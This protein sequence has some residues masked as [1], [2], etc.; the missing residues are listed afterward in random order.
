MDGRRLLVAATVLV[1]IAVLVLTNGADDV[2]PETTSAVADAAIT[3]TTNPPTST[4][5]PITTTAP[6]STSSTLAPITTGAPDSEFLSAI[7]AV[8]AD[9]LHASWREGCPLAIEG[10]SAVDVSFWSYNGL[11]NTGRLIVATDLA[12]DMVAIMQDL[13]EA[14]FP[15]ERMAPVDAFGGD[16]D[17]S[18][19]ANNTSAF[20]CRQVTGGSAWSEHSYGRAIDINPLVNPY[21]RGSTVLPPEG[22]AYA[23]RERDAPGMIHAGDVVVDVFAARGWEWGGYWTSSKDYQHFS[24]TGR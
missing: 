21:V 1:A 20:N 17:R 8:T 6:A 12:E 23:D 15:I 10:L 3:S 11:V 7:S 4:T 2:A 16:D 14:R 22:A 18:M 13:Y 24:T 5:S 9:D 19:A